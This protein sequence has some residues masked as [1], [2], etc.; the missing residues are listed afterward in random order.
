M[1]RIASSLEVHQTDT[2]KTWLAALKDSDARV[3]ILVRITR[4]QAGN[5]GSAHSVGGKVSEL[6]IDV[7]P[8][9]RVYFTQTGPTIVL[10]L[11]GG[12][13]RTQDADIRLP[14]RMIEGL[15]ELSRG[16]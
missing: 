14:K 2:F 5:L 8:G 16:H 3:R 10:L 13:K 12:N 6:V 15:K 9:Y 4:L 7:G 1:S 11:C